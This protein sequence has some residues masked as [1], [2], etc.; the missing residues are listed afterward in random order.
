M[1]AQSCAKGQLH[2][3]NLGDCHLESG[4]IL[5]QCRVGYRTFGR[6]D[7]AGDN[8]VR[9]PT[10][11]CG[12]SDELTGFF[13][14]GPT[15]QHLVDA[16]RFFGIAV[17]ALGNGVLSS[18]SNTPAPQHGPDF[19]AITMRDMVQ[20]EYRLVAEVLHLKHLHA[21]V[22]LSMGGEQTFV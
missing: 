18:P 9:I 16:T 20:A 4:A 15:A 8:A 21:V 13:G 5:H 11:L 2:V 10:W 12:T 19:P 1:F 3:A 14:D 6:L 22:G 7:A 17:D